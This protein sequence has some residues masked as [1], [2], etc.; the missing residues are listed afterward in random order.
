M[1]E[2][3]LLEY[4][5]LRAMGMTALDAYAYVCCAD[6]SIRGVQRNA[7]S[8]YHRCNRF[9]GPQRYISRNYSLSI[10]SI[11][12]SVWPMLLARKA[13]ITKH[14]NLAGYEGA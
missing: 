12:P 14:G 7:Y 1:N 8:E 11:A 6:M 10:V 2:R 3:Q 4:K 9:S 13:Y 5:K